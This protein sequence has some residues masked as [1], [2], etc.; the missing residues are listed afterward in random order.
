MDNLTIFTVL[1]TAGFWVY[2]AIPALGALMAHKRKHHH[3]PNT[4]SNTIDSVTD[5]F[6]VIKKSTPLILDFFITASV[7]SLFSL[8]GTQGTMISF[9]ISD[10]F[11]FVIVIT[12]IMWSGIK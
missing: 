3:K 11:S 7:L 5:Y 10:I 8:Q 12:T 6:S 2:E 4:I 9:L 1:L